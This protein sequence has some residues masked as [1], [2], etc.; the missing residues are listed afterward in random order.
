MFADLSPRRGVVALACAA[1]A[2]VLLASSRGALHDTAACGADATCAAALCGFVVLRGGRRE[3]RVLREL[4]ALSYVV[5]LG[6]GIVRS[7]LTVTPL[8][9]AVFDQYGRAYFLGLLTAVTF[10]HLWARNRR[11]Q[12]I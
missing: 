5:A 12:G 7:C 6:L 11:T 2:C 8:D 1:G 4:Y 3:R 9:A 10:A